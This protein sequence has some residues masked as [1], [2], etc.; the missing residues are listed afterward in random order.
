MDPTI[1]SLTAEL[2]KYKK[3][4]AELKKVVCAKAPGPLGLIQSIGDDLLNRQNSSN[5]WHSSTLESINDLKPDY[6]GKVG[7]HL[8]QQ[9]CVNGTIKCE[10]TEDKNSTDGTYDLK[11]NDKKVEIKTARLG[12]NASFQHETLKTDGYDYILF[13]DITPDYFYITLLPRFDMKERHPIIG[14]KPHPRK[15]TSDVFK[16][17]FGESNIKRSI[18]A[19]TSLKVDATVSMESVVSFLNAKCV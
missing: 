18:V 15:G 3:E 12:V 7:E 1:A 13:V 16:L 10:Y 14:R 9:L 4:N 11:I 8:I 6:A 19:G 17:D 5:E 2:E